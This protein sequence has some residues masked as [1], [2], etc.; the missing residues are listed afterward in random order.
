MLGQCGTLRETSGI[1]MLLSCLVIVVG[2]QL[3]EVGGDSVV[4]TGS[5]MTCQVSNTI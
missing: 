2:V 3:S 5:A 1:V 4:I